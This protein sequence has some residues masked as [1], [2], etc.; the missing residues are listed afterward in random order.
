M[1]HFLGILGKQNSLG[2]YVF[3]GKSMGGYSDKPRRWTFL[4]H[5]RTSDLIRHWLLPANR[6]RGYWY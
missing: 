5:P 4:Q 6:I 1:Q 2:R 3:P